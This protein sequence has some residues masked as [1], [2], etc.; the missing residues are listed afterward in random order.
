MRIV[1]PKIE[2]YNTKPETAFKY[3]V[4]IRNRTR[5]ERLIKKLNVAARREEM[6]A[7]LPFWTTGRG[8]VRI[9]EYRHGVPY[10]SLI[11]W[12]EPGTPYQTVFTSPL[13]DLWPKLA[14]VPTTFLEDLELSIL[15]RLATSVDRLSSTE[16]TTPLTVSLVNPKF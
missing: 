7:G 1:Q 6:R 8:R 10:Y 3:A 14:Q 15:I 13:N 9:L 16:T 5:F 12:W 2:K 11:D 4:F